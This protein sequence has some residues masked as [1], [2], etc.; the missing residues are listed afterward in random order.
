MKKNKIVKWIVTL[1]PVIVIMVLV[2]IFYLPG[3]L[4][5]SENKYES[6]SEE[7]ERE[8]REKAGFDKPNGFSDFYHLITTPIG[9]QKSSYPTNY[10]FL[11]YKK[12]ISKSKNLKS[13]DLYYGWVQRGP[14]NVGGRT[15]TIIVDP[16]D[17]SHQ[18]WIAASVSGGIWRTTNGGNSWTNLTDNMP[19]LSTNT[20][21]MAPSNHNIIYVGTGEGYGGFGMVGGNGIFV[22]YNRGG[23][24]GIIESTTEGDNFKFVNKIFVDPVNSDIIVAATNKGIFKSL[25]RGSSW[26]TVYNTCHMVQDLIANPKNPSV[27]YAGVNSLGVIKSYDKGS[28]WISAY[29]G[30][31]DGKRFSLA[32]SEVDTSYIYTSVETPAHTTELYI[33]SNGAKTWNKLN[34]YD[35]TFIDFFVSQGWFNNVIAAHPFDNKKVFIGGVYL[36]SIEFK[37]TVSESEEQVQRVDTFGTGS[38]LNFINFGGAHFSG[39]L[40]TGLEEDAEVDAE[41]FVPVEILFGPGKSQKAYR[42]TVPE[43]EGPG[44]P[45]EDYSYQNYINVPFQV[46][47]IKNNTQLMV[48]FRDQERD[49]KFN[50]IDRDPDEVIKGREYIYIHSIPYSETPNSNIAKAGGHYY[51]MLYFFWPVLREDG[52]WNENALPVSKLEVKYGKFNLQNATTTVL[53]DKTRNKDLHVD[54]HDLKMIITNAVNKEFTILNANDGGLGISEDGGDTWRQIKNGYITTQFYG[55]AKKPGA[56]EFIGGTQDNGTWKSPENQNASSTSEYDFKI[57]GDGFEALWHPIYPQ[58]IIGSWYYN[59]FMVSIDGGETWK[60][61]TKGIATNDGPFITRLSNSP[62]NPNLVFAVGNLGV[63]RHTSFCMGQFGWNMIELGTGWAIDETV[64]SSHNVEVSLADPNIVWA[65]AGMHADPDLHVFISKDKGLTF[66]TVHN[67]Y[68]REMGYLTSIAT[69]PT[70]PATAYLLYSLPNLPKIIRTTNYGESWE[71]I[72]GFG[73]DSTSSNGFP[74]VM[75]YSLLVMPYNTNIIWAGTEIGIFE[76]TNNGVSWHYAS[77]GLPAVSVWQMFV[78]DNTIV[79][80]TH[81]RGIWTANLYPVSI[82]TNITNNQFEIYPNPSTGLVHLELTAEDSGYTEVHIFDLSG[83]EVYSDKIYKADLNLDHE[84]NLGRLSSGIYVIS[85]EFDKKTYSS[86]LIIQ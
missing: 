45:P 42:F 5:E 30:I 79:A 59:N 22:T 39:C 15:R 58:R 28:T 6:E 72:S 10:S 9:K 86:R 43:G 67:F 20:M 74:D 55:V 13:S 12:A 66:D 38:F 31:G 7:E 83:R 49:G 64:S 51:K 41:D 33:S 23:S 71:D 21:T 40:S 14:G 56:N 48:S 3:K 85:V 18:T 32:I 24:W 54:H 77:N 1:L 2:L 17:P 25:N 75:V 34:D 26:N 60:D 69:H 29:E 53:A 81:G 73:Q 76:S 4:F 47:D 63:Y 37:S 84:L 52:T 65:G 78:Q 70:D 27:M 46:W 11:E 44:V 61:A 50:L 16:D 82:P 19:N 35:N 8:E 80:A 57:S 62:Q 36:G 68:S